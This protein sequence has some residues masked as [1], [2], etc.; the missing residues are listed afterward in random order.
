MQQHRH[1]QRRQHSAQQIGCRRRAYG[2]GHVATRH[3]GERDGRLHRGRQ[4]ADKQHAQ[5]QRRRQQTGE[6]RPQP[7]AQRRKQD[8]GARKDQRV[9][10]HILHTRHDGVCG[11]ARAMQEE[12]QRNGHIAGHHHEGRAL[13]HRG[14]EA[15]EHHRGD[16]DER[17][18]VGQE[19]AHGG[20]MVEKLR[21]L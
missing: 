10:A 12:Q 1:Q 16:Q 17:E 20:R 2:A 9:Q 19:A 7:Q 15:G 5:P 18:L 8:E 4:G 21:E 6:Q 3:G 11:Q 13:A 14:K